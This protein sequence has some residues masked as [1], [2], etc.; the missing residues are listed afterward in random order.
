[1]GR[2]IGIVAIS[3][4]GSALC[5]RKLGRL[6]TQ[7]EDPGARPRITLHNLPFGNYL[8]AFHSNDWETI[9]QML[10]WSAE[11][12]AAVGADFLILPDNLAHHAIHFAE[13]GSGAPWINMV[14]LVA[15]QVARDERKTMGIVGTKM[16]MNGS[17]YQSV[18]GMRGVTLLTP[19]EGD[20]DAID[21]IIFG[22]L[23]EGRV[24]RSSREQVVSA[25]EALRS[26]G[27][28]GLILGSTEA[29]LLVDQH[30]CSLPTYDPVDLLVHEAMKRAAAG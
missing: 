20:A 24:E 22:E 10:R 18:L 1:V 30:S 29:P 11:T 6:A 21:R 13:P 27:C 9:G 5:Y 8:D 16:M 14:D 12:L 7:I 28:E 26:R 3:P 17:V 23:V 15:E 2:H 19:E 4:E 25:I